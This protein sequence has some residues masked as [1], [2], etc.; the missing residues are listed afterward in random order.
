MPTK[1]NAIFQAL[2]KLL[3][4]SAFAKS[5]SIIAGSTTLSQIIAFAA[6]PALTRLYTPNDFGLF[7]AYLSIIVFGTVTASFRYE[8]AIFIP[9]KDRDAIQLLALSIG[10]TI[11]SSSLF[12]VFLRFLQW[13]SLIP[14]KY[15]PLASY[16]WIGAL[17]VCGFGIFQALNN[18]ALRKKAFS[19]VATTK[20]YQTISM[21]AVQLV[22]G[23]YGKPTVSYLLAGDLIGRI[24]SV[25]SLLRT[26]RK[27]S[28]SLISEVNAQAVLCQSRRYFKF[29]LVSTPSALLNAAGIYLPMLLLG[30][31]FGSSTLGHFALVERVMGAPTILIGGAIAQVYMEKVA[32]LGKDNPKELHRLFLSTCWKLLKLGIIPYTLAAILGPWFFRTVFGAPWSESGQ[33]AMILAPAYLVAFVLWPLLSTLSILEHQSWQLAWDISRMVFTLGGLWICHRLN[34]KPTIAIF[35]YGMTLSLFYMVHALLSQVAIRKR[36][37]LFL[38]ANN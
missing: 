24:T 30:E 32:R 8:L 29:P 5:V 17:A 22:A 28:R 33:F 7:Q 31:Y 38:A 13:A 25:F 27:E 3:P 4:Q 2:G 19:V 11:L 14:E 35:I 12:F 18:W 9:E 37:L 26:H 10:L 21:L 34:V 23:F 15:Q 6:A 16:F 1:F 36:M 20:I